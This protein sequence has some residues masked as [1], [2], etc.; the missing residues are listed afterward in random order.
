MYR[1]R[2]IVVFTLLAVLLAL[3]VFC[4]YSLVRGV[5]AVTGT[6][7]GSSRVALE[8][9][10]VP[11]PHPAYAVRKCTAD[12]VTLSLGANT[13][14]VESGG[15]VEF[16]ATLTRDGGGS[17]LIETSGAGMVLTITSGDETVWRSDS[18]PVDTRWLLL[19]KGDR[20]ESVT[21]W[22]TNRTGG[23]CEADASLAKVDAG[24]YVASMAVKDHPKIKSGSV[25]VKVE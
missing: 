20:D 5:G 11:N 15:S 19:A 1:R 14:T 18:C 12:D 21:T 2:R 24:T 25:V 8:R 7:V 3:A 22:N 9:S 6:G 23:E 10:T 13:T 16:T 17:C 4:V